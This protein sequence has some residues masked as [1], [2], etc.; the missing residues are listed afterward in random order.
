MKKKN[1]KIAFVFKPAKAN[2]RQLIHKWLA[3]DYIKEWIHGQGLQ[4]TLKGIEKFFKGDCGTQYWIAYDKDTPF[5]FLITSE[6]GE[7][8]MTL[9]LF[10]CDKS[11]LGKGFAVPMIHEFLTSQFPHKKRVLIDPEAT[12]ERAI[13]VYK[14]AGFKIIGEFIASWHPVPHYKMELQIKDLLKRVE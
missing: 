1:P 11:Y 13:H 10:I 9:D 6:E 7:D 4:N 8:A 2:D 12:N 5:A 3:Q 14:K